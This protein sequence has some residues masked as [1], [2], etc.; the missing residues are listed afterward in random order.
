MTMRIIT[1]E[2]HF[3][4]PALMDRFGRQSFHNK[5]EQLCD[6]NERRI[7]EMNAA[8]IDMQVLSLTSPGTELLAAEEA[9]KIASST[10]D[11]LAAAIE[12]HPSRFAGLAAL[13]T[14]APDLAADELERMVCQHGF[15]GA[16]INGHIQG[17]YLDDKF[18]WPILE[19]AEAY[20]VPIYLHPAPPPQPV[21]DAYYTGNF[22]PEVT[23][24]LS[25]AGWGWHIETA[26]H[27]LRLILSGAFDRYPKLQIIIGH[28]GEALPFMLSRIDLVLQPKLTKLQRS[29]AAYLRENI[30]YTF[31]GFNFTSAFLNLLLE[32][33][34]DRI[35]FSVDYPYGSMEK[36]RAFLT[37]LPVSSADREK[38]AHGNAE[39]L[40]RL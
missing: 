14:A 8:G 39:L 15:R 4:S 5:G 35:M 32:V 27:V 2:E 30:H 10:N 25:T 19:R 9:V 33:G 37:Q 3:A 31:S 12:R 34:V 24:M 16:V 18:F 38:I 11:F 6:L 1:L 7:A 26:V 29:M 23:F 13:P 22:S 20:Q 40:L 36:G 21:I 17:R 28:M